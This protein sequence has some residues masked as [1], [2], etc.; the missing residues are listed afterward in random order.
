[1]H[2]SQNLMNALAGLAGLL[3]ACAAT[4]AHAVIGVYDKYWVTTEA[5]A[6]APGG[7][8]GFHAYNPASSAIDSLP[9]TQWSGG[10][11]FTVGGSFDTSG[12][13]TS[14]L[15]S[16]A[17]IGM[18]GP[19]LASGD[20]SF[21]RAAAD[22]SNGSLRAAVENKTAGGYVF[23]RAVA[24][25]HDIVTLTVAGADAQTRTR[26]SVNFT[27]DGSFAS[28]G[29]DIYGNG[30]DATV[31]AYLYLNNTSSAQGSLGAYAMAQWRQIDPNLQT[32]TLVSATEGFSNAGSA[33]NTGDV[34]GAGSWAG[35]TPN[36]MN[37][38]GSFDIIG[39]SV[40]LNPTFTL[41]VDCSMAICDFGN[42]ARFSFV[43]LPDNVSYSS[44]SGVFLSPVPE[45][46]SWALMLVG[47]GWVMQ[48]SRC[49]QRR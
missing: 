12:G 20:T 47:L 48:R 32:P 42:T 10:G 18:A 41:I 8:G 15:S 43:N 11:N 19:S 40:T 26:I 46:S 38:S 6:Y 37:F 45:P 22:L 3:A 30:P 44:D 49:R 29:T 23:G 7:S 17:A 39:S 9:G 21:A 28:T 2:R 36:L 16:A 27:V 4:P 1:M 5:G 13:R 31:Q 14:A 35:S 25:M 24:Q 34:N 33:F